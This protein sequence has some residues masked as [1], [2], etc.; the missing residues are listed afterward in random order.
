MQYQDIAYDVRN[1]AAW[2]TINRPEKYNAFRGVDLRGTHR[3]LQ[4]CRMGQSHRRHR[5]YR[6]RRARRFAPAAISRPMMVR[7]MTAAA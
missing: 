2:I 3:R 7:P 6:R 1:S 5:S 4:P